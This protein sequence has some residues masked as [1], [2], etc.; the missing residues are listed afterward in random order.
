MQQML[1]AMHA[2][3]DQFTGNNVHLYQI[4]GNQSRDHTKSS[5]NQER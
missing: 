4:G 3:L 2:R 5:H 1:V